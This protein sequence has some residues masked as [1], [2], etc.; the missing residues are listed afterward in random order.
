MSP[1]SRLVASRMTIELIATVQL[2]RW[3]TF[4]LDVYGKV[5]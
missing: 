1:E 5:Y 3:V 2:Y 4:G